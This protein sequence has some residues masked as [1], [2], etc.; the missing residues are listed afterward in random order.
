[1]TDVTVGARGTL[2]LGSAHA[3]KPA[4]LLWLEP[5]TGRRHQLRLHTAHHGHAIVGDLTYAGDRSC[6]R[7]FLHAAALDLPVVLVDLVHMEAAR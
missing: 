4:T 2:R 1:M 5:R 6:Y 3:G 7:T